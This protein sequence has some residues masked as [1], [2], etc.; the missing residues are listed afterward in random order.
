MEGKTYYEVISADPERFEMFNQTL[1][2]MDAEMPV[3][4]MFPFGSIKEQVQAEPDRPFIVDVG[5]GMGK[6]LNSI[7]EEAPQGFGAECVLQDRADVLASIPQ[8][9]IPGVKKMEHDFFTPQPVKSRCQSRL[10][11]S[12][13]S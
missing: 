5:G 6:V 1:V 4:G 3:R 13:C 2:Q 9:S 10:P 7:L 12:A 11:R 8:E